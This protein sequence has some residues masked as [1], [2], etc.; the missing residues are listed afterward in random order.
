MAPYFGAVL[1]SVPQ[2]P[3]GRTTNIANV[4]SQVY[5]N[6][7]IGNCTIAGKAH[8][9]GCFTGNANPPPAIFATAQIESDYFRLT[10]GPDSGLDEITVLEDWRD[11]KAPLLGA[12]HNISGFASV[13]ATNTAH[14]EFAIFAFFN[15]YLGLSLP[16]AYIDPPPSRNGFIWDEAGDPNPDNGH[17]IVAVDADAKGIYV[18]TW[19]LWGIMT[20][21]A[22]AKYLVPNVGGEFHV[23]LTN[24]IIEQAKQVTPSNFNFAQ[25][26][27]D[28]P[29]IAA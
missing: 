1:P 6:D 29:Q 24:E 22:L 20:W 15:G 16:D 19:G 11:N 27:T 5:G 9:I 3:W 13:D 28:L 14:V 25:L 18:L 2:G 23:A 17:C 7:S 26:Q 12:Q 8:L 21:R 4:I 10:G